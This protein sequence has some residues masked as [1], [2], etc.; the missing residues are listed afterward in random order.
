MNE[1]KPLIITGIRA[2]NFTRLSRVDL[3]ISKQGIIPI[4]GKNGSGKTS[5]IELINSAL[6]GKGACPKDPIKHG[7]EFAEIGLKLSPI[8]GEGDE[9]EITRTFSADGGSKLQALE[10]DKRR[11]QT[12]L[13]SLLGELRD[14]Q[15]F[16]ELP[17]QK[18]IEQIFGMVDLG[19]FSIED[20]KDQEAA[21]VEARRDLGRDKS[22]LESELGALREQAEGY[23]PFDS[24]D[25]AELNAQFDLA[26]EA[27]AQHDEHRREAE[28][29]ERQGKAERENGENLKAEKLRLRERLEEIEDEIKESEENVG[30]LRQEYQEAREAAQEALGTAPTVEEAREAR[31]KAQAAFAEM[32]GKKA[33]HDQAEAKEQELEATSIAHQ[34]AQERIDEIREARAKALSA[35]AWPASGMGFDPEEQTLTLNGVR[36][37]QAS[38]AERFTAA[39][40]ISIAQPSR[41]HALWI[42]NG[43]LLD[44]EKLGIIAQECEAAGYQVWTE[45]VSEEPGEGIFLEDGVAEQEVTA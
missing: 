3:G 33:A 38:A 15:D 36:W 40:Q 1:S 35:A 23:E 21:Q 7:A 41:V 42:K 22:R 14:P 10:G 20:S 6:K 45:I 28:D 34:G 19:G 9:I 5:L 4:R 44:S 8:D 13:N 24:L 18:Q 17:R 16:L 11:K 39:T 26:V 27:K 43:S 32:N 31:D 30:R 2:R 29:L 25:L 12:D 37:D